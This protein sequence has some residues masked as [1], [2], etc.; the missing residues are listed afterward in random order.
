MKLSGPTSPTASNGNGPL[1]EYK[2]EGDSDQVED[3][4]PW[5]EGSSTTPDDGF[6]IDQADVEVEIE[7]PQ[8][9][10]DDQEYK[11]IT[12]DPVSLDPDPIQ[13]GSSF[14]QVGHVVLGGRFVKKIYLN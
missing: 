14:G 3:N 13:A 8:N 9:E 7:I 6:M 1:F 2:Y 12:W 4:S 10:G 11:V 5:G